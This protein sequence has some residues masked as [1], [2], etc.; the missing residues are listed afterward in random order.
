MLIQHWEFCNGRYTFCTFTCEEDLWKT[1]V[2]SY[3]IMK[4]THASEKD[5]CFLALWN[6]SMYLTYITF[7]K[8][9]FFK[10]SFNLIY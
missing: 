10:T 5:W 3:E 2:L 9:T 7:F 8:H 1:C 4:F 6:T